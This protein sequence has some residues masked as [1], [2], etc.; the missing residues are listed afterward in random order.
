MRCCACRFK[1]QA[2]VGPHLHPSRTG[3]EVSPA[4]Y[5]LMWD[6]R[7]HQGQR[8]SS[9]CSPPC[10]SFTRR[11]PELLQIYAESAQID[12]LRHIKQPLHRRV[13]KNSEHPLCTDVT[14]VC[15]PLS[16]VAAVLGSHWLAWMLHGCLALSILLQPLGAVD[17]SADTHVSFLFVCDES[18]R[19]SLSTL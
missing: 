17:D 10:A 9:C 12:G 15:A 8:Y 6:I 16:F 3:I 14:P 19:L 7:L 2:C 13:C 4:G 5:R 18:G 1:A 11:V